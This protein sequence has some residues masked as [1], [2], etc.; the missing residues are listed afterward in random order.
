[1]NIIFLH[2]ALGTSKDLVPLMELFKEKGH[3]TFAFDFSGHGSASSWPEEFR[4]DLFARELDAY[5]KSHSLQNPIIFGH[6]MGGY[7]A[8]Y[9]QAHFG[10]SPVS[11]IFCYG[12]KFNWTEQ[13]VAR[14]LP[15]LDPD[16]LL[17]KFPN[18]AAS[19][20]AKHG[21]RWKGLLRSTAHMMRNLEKLDGLTKED[22]EDIQIPVYLLLGDQDRAVTTEET[23]AA[24]DQLHRGE[25]RTIS[26]SKHDL[27]RT[28]LKEVSQVVLELLV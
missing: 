4:I 5:L 3:D 6:S 14:E 17:D 23:H 22:L 7:V 16:N 2:G 8:L 27:E 12:T 11:K 1:M 26:H 13:A 20:Q 18:F 19:L 21:Q 10:D 9:H 25:I 15:M 28:N 24:R